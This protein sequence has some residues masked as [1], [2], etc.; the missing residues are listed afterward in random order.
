MKTF[1]MTQIRNL[2]GGGASYLIIGLGAA[3]AIQY[4]QVGELRKKESRLTEERDT[5]IA[6]AAEK[7]TLIASQS[8]QYRRQ[9]ETRKDEENAEAI[10]N[11]VPDSHHCMRSAPV[12]SALEWLR[13]HEAASTQIDND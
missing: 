7:D 1:L 2:M 12:R 8:R 5:A 6:L 13:E 9:I 10:I 4:W 11:A 3:I